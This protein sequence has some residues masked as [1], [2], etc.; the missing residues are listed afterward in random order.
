M[1]N[2]SRKG[3]NNVVIISMLLMIFFLN[4]LH[5]KL[6]PSEPELGIQA[7]LPEQSFILT[8]AFP[9]Y[10]IERIGTSWRIEKPHNTADF[11]EQQLRSLVSQW[12]R[13][14]LEVVAKPT[15]DTEALSVAQFWLATQELPLSYQLYQQQQQFWL[16]DKQTQRWFNL[17]KMHAQQLFNP[18]L[19]DQTSNQS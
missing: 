11:S 7:V 15:L 14:Q 9:G 4:G 17:P 1:I 5:H 13:L 2:L 18:I 3:W 16:Y 10:K 8:L 6:N 12:Q 19:A